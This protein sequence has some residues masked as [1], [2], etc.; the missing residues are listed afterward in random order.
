[1]DLYWEKQLA[2]MY[3]NKNTVQWNYTA[4]Y[5]NT[6]SIIYLNYKFIAFHMTWK[7]Y[8]LFINQMLSNDIKEAIKISIYAV[9]S[10]PKFNIIYGRHVIVRKLNPIASLFNKLPLNVYWYSFY[11]RP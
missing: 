8:T 9:I 7:L 11:P 4:F 10:M 6:F 2:L 5:G 3:N 1:M